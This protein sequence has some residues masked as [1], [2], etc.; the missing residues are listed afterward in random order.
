MPRKNQE[1][2]RSKYEKDTALLM[3]AHAPA[4]AGGR[5]RERNRQESTFDT[6]VRQETDTKKRKDR[7]G[8]RRDCAMC[9]TR[10]GHGC[11]ELIDAMEFGWM[12]IH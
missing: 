10:E 9:G 12:T 2:R 11:P 4:N 5:Q 8:Q 7:S 3:N 1:E 6:F